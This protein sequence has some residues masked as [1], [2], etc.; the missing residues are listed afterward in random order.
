MGDAVGV[1]GL[2]IMGSAMSNNLMEFGFKVHGYDIDPAAIERFKGDGGRACSSCSAVAENASHIVLSLPN[3]AALAT[4]SSEMST[5]GHTDCVLIETSTLALADKNAAHEVLTGSGIALL[6]CPLSGTG[7]QAQTGDIAVYASGGHDAYLAVEHLF[8]GFARSYVYLGE[9]G[10]GSRMK[11]IANLLVAVHNVAAGEAFALAARA[12][13][14]LNTVRETIGKGVGSS[15]IFEVRGPLMVEDRYTPPTMKVD[16]FQKDL[17]IIDEFARS[18]GASTPLLDAV[19]P[20]YDAAQAQ[21]Y[22]ASDTAVVRK[23]IG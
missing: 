7:A 5:S 21:G 23:I 10:N 9:F 16:M 18:V 8:P 2:G 13:L 11:Y 17:D 20:I 6:D 3:A 1:I 4:V 22:G 15:R 19:R 14:D 12:G